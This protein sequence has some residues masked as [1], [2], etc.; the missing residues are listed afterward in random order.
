M[1][2]AGERGS[3]IDTWN[4]NPRAFVW[5]TKTADHILESIARYCQRIKD[6]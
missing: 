2:Q 4:D 5:T 1:P 3:G 6:S